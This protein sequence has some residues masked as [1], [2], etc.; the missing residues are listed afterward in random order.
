MRRSKLGVGDIV[1]FDANGTAT[2]TTKATNLHEGM[3][4]YCEVQDAKEAQK[5]CDKLNR[6]QQ[7]ESMSSEQS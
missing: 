2:F 1:F 4:I 6:P 7:T 3:K 5:I